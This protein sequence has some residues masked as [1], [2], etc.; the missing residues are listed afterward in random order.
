MATVNFSLRPAWRNYWP[1]LVLA[2]GLVVAAVV[3]GLTGVGLPFAL[4]CGAGAVLVY[5]YIML[6]RYSWRFTIDEN[7]ISRHKGIISRNQQSIRLAD[8]RSVELNQS[9]WQRLMGLGDLSFY[10]SGSDD[11]EVRFFGIHSPATH[12]DKIYGAIDQLE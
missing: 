10:S 8:L 6:Q 9:L 7:R 1:S 4:A 3:L 12:R 5:G 11:A 2:N